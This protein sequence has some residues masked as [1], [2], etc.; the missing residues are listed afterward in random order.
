MKNKTLVVSC[1]IVVL[2]IVIVIGTR[3]ISFAEKITKDFF[4][5]IIVV[6]SKPIDYFKEVINKLNSNVYEENKVL[7]NNINSYDALLVSNK[8][9]QYEINT[10][11]E[12]LGLKNSLLDY[13]V[14]SS[15]V[16]N[17]NLG[18]WYDTFVIDKGSNDGVV[19]NMAVVNNV[20][21]IGYI[22]D[23]SYTTST[24][25]IITSNL[26]NKISVKIDNDGEYVYGLIS[27]YKD[28][29]FLIEGVGEDVV[30]DSVVTTTGMGDIFPSGIMIGKV[31]EIVP[32]NFGLSR[33]YKVKSDIDYNL[34]SYV[35][36]LK[37]IS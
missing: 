17:R 14:I 7:K 33:V 1:I 31:K 19:N 24:V 37:R 20:G 34:I 35:S 30:I 21:L 13:E 18:Y 29:F 28:G 3:K 4:S 8:E 32:D 9:L 16:I 10:L 12:L 22:E 11:K 2:L 36:V 26:K 5:N 25:K 6:V 15:T 23:S 27:G